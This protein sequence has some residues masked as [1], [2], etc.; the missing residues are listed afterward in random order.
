MQR[1][2]WQQRA[3]F[4]A[5][6]LLEHYFPKSTAIQRAR[7]AARRRIVADIRRGRRGTVS[8]VERVSA[9]SPGEFRRRNLKPGIP[10]I[11]EG[12]ARE[13][14]LAT[15]WSFDN[16][17]R[18]YGGETIKLVQR[19]GL[20]DDEFIGIRE[21]SEEIEFG[22]FLDQV[23][24]GGRKYMRFSPLLEKFPEL[25]ADFDHEFFKQMTGNGWG[26]TYQ[27]FMGAVGTYT[28]LHNAMTGFF[29]VNVCGSKR[30]VFIPNHYLAVLNPSADG[31]GYNHSEAELDLSN[32]DRFPGL[33]CVDRFEALIHPGD[34]L[35]V[36]SW[37]W[38]CVR[39]EAP[40]IG[41]RCGFVYPQGMLRESST[42]SFIRLFAARNPSTL[43]ALVHV[44]FRKDLPDRDRLL[45]TPGLFRE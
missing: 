45:V 6:F 22:E 31:Y 38:H 18:R 40:T 1:V 30:W 25:R 44:L 9:I 12:A 24:H 23:L 5:A 4:N 17:K 33:E 43:E 7:S 8:A 14:P 35:Y 41:V 11:I 37:M 3:A 42:L 36:P 19:K 21:F 15:R 28:P 27:L 16:F 2:A 26:I 29:F 10:L 39:N 13:W 32:V 20:S 34:V